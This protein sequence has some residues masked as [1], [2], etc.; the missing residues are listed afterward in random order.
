M[1]LRGPLSPPPPAQ[2]SQLSSSFTSSFSSSIRTSEGYIFFDIDCEACKKSSSLAAGVGIVDTDADVVVMS[3]EDVQTTEERRGA[4]GL[5]H[6]Y[7]PQYHES[8]EQSLVGLARRYMAMCQREDNDARRRRRD[9]VGRRAYVLTRIDGRQGIHMYI[10]ISLRMHEN[11]DFIAALR[12][13]FCK[14]NRAGYCCRQTG[15][16]F[17]VD[18]KPR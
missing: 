9:D 5:P 2:L 12:L 16:Y 8:M 14:G 1:A 10:P 18:W 11:L 3:L 7:L 17:A 15:H 13:L 4:A 6:C